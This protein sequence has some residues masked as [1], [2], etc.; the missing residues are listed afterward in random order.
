MTSKKKTLILDGNNIIHRTFHANNRS[1]EPEE[2][3]IALCVHSA[4]TTMNYYFNRF[5]PDEVVITFDS[6]SWRKEYTKD[7]SKCVTNKKYKGHRKDKMTPK[8]LQMRRM[9]EEHIDELHQMLDENTSILVLRGDYLEGDDLIAGYIQMHRNE[10][11]VVVSGDKDMMQLLRYEGVTLIDPATGK[12]RTLVDYDNDADLFVF[13]KCIRGEG[14][15]GDNVQSSYP[16]LR[17]DK[18]KRAYYDEFE[19]TNV[20]NH[21]FTQLEAVGE[22][23]EEVEYTTGQL[24]EEN[25]LLMNLSKQPK[26]IKVRMVHTI[27]QAK[28]NRG[29][30]DHWK[31]IKFCKRNE[32]EK[33][34]E[35]V[36]DFVP[37]L[38]IKPS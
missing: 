8:Q 33:I 1:N 30:Y 29:R 37:L 13:E 5:H 15:T 34:C 21:T 2:V 24:F 14:K 6:H 18:L 27:E 25:Q 7:L 31:F 11:H 12:E 26:K 20:M 16:R 9:L 38:A 35:Q 19:R 36:E 28:K 32:L 23:Y 3:V 4:I 10:D 17:K 22:D